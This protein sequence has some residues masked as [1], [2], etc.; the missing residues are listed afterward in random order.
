MAKVA[1]ISASESPPSYVHLEVGGRKP[2]AAERVAG[3]PHDLDLGEHGVFAYD[4]EVPLVV[5]ALAA[6]RHA[7]V[8]EALRDRRPL[9]REGKLLLAL[10]DHSRERRRHLGAKGE[11]ALGLVEKVVY[12]LSDLLAR[13]ARKKLVALHDARVVLSEARRLAR[14]AKRVEHA[15]AP[16]HV[17]GIEVAHPARGLK[18]DLVCHVWY[19]PKNRRR[20][21]G[22]AGRLTGPEGRRQGRGRRAPAAEVRAESPPRARQGSRG[23]R[24]HCGRD[25]SP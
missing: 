4:V 16:R 13:L 12:L 1:S 7:L 10:R 3:G 20:G 21:Q 25:A 2:H 17:L 6:L 19:Y 8:S 9:E 23:R 14:C 15:I 18:T 22:V 11:V 24:C 5:L